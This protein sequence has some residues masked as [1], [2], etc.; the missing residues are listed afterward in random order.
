MTEQQR[1]WM[2]ITNG[3]DGSNGLILIKSQA[4][5]EKVELLAEQGDEQF[6][7]GD[8]LQVRDLWFAP[9]FDID[10]WVE[11]NFYGYSDEDILE[12]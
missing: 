6:A 4:A 7:S 10:S 9:D 3:G 1:I 11:K 8:G 2:I 12:N 5:L